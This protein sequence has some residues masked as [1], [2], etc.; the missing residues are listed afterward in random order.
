MTVTD[1]NSIDTS[2]NSNNP[3]KS[4][5]KGVKFILWIGI[6]MVVIGFLMLFN[7]G[8]DHPWIMIIGML[9]VATGAFTAV[10]AKFYT[11]W[12]SS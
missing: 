2:D 12:K 8:E 3:V 9:S 4:D 10:I 11:W 6:A 1:Q 5:N 7:A